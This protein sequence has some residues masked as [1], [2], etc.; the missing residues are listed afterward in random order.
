MKEYLY[1][2]HGGS[3]E[4]VHGL[5]ARLVIQFLKGELEL[6]KTKQTPAISKKAR[7]D[8]SFFFFYTVQRIV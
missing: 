3:C 2:T 8:I 5:G 1:W 4:F 6:V 7:D